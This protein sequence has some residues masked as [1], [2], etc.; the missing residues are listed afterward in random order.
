MKQ[1]FMALL[2]LNAASA[3]ADTNYIIGCNAKGL[4]C[5][6]DQTA[7]VPD[8][9]LN[10]HALFK[11]SY[12]FTCGA[13]L[14]PYQSRVFAY[15]GASQ[16]SK[17]W[18]QYK[19][20]GE[21]QVTGYGPVK[22][23]DDKPLEL[24]ETYLGKCG[25]YIDKVVSTPSSQQLAQWEGTR[26]ELLRQLDGVKDLYNKRPQIMFWQDMYSK[27]PNSFR[28]IIQNMIDDLKAKVDEDALAE[29]DLIQY[30]AILSAAPD[31]QLKHALGRVK[32]AAEDVI[33]RANE[34]V[35]SKVQAGLDR[36]QDLVAK[37]S[38]I[39]ALIGQ[40]G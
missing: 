33:K 5:A 20:A 34:L 13:T 1:V 39:E 22:L 28:P 4:G 38:E 27:D 35:E 21:I 15:A 32:T 36:D 11:V 23:G 17:G 10:Y 18:L 30:E 26:L 8:T 14:N 16:V 12:R 29:L 7:E 40:G 2:L 37:C 6:V 19:N 9:A 24:S 3:L 31:K 25:L